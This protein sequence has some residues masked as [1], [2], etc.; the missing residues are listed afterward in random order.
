[1]VKG[2]TVCSVKKR[3]LQRLWPIEDS[4]NIYIEKERRSKRETGQTNFVT[5]YWTWRA[6][7]E[8]VGNENNLLGASLTAEGETALHIADVEG[9]AGIVEWFSARWHHSS[10]YR[11][12][13]GVEQPFHVHFLEGMSRWLGPWWI[14]MRNCLPLK[15]DEICNPVVEAASYGHVDLVHY[16]CHRTPPNM[17]DPIKVS[18]SGIFFS[19]TV[20]LPIY[21]HGTW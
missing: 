19:V 13:G 14:N 5:G 21:I 8:Q 15:N 11:K 17:L 12:V 4:K 20:L 10:W 6:V 2:R 9:Q 3:K 16:L 1:M 7:R 18:K